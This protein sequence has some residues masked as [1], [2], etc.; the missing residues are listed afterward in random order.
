MADFQHGWLYVASG[1]FLPPTQ[2][3]QHN[4]FNLSNPANPLAVGTAPSIGNKPHSIGL[5]DHYIVHGGQTPSLYLYDFLTGA[6]VRTAVTGVNPVDMGAQP[7]FE[8]RATNGYISDP[9]Q[10][11][12]TRFD[13]DDP[14]AGSVTTVLAGL[15]AIGFKIGS[16]HPLGNLLV[17]S[18]SQA[19]G[20]ATF[21]IGDPLQPV[22]LDTLVT[23]NDVYTSMAYGS[24]LYACEAGQGI[25]VYDF[26][27]PRNVVETG[28]LPLPSSLEYNPRYVTI[29][30]GKGYVASGFV[31]GA[32]QGTLVE[33]DALA[34]SP[35]ITRTF[36]LGST[37]DWKYSDFA[38]PIGNMAFL[39]GSG[40]ATYSALIS[41]ESTADTLGPRV[42]HAN[43]PDFAVGVPTTARIGFSMSE[44]IDV[45]SL[46]A[47][48]FRL[49]PV[50]PPNSPA[51]TG[52]Y[53]VKHYGIINFAPDEPLLSNTTYE[54]D[55][56]FGGIRDLVGNGLRQAYHA[57]FTTGVGD[58][59]AS[60]RTHHWR[61]DGNELD[62]VGSNHGTPSATL[63]Y[64]PGQIG[65]AAYFDGAASIA[66]GT[67]SLPAS[68]S[69]SAWVWV[70]PTAT[71]SQTIIANSASG[72]SSPGYK[73]FVNSPGTTDGTVHL[74]TTT[75]LISADAVT[76]A[77]VLPAGSWHWVAVRR[78]GSTARIYVDGCDRTASSIVASGFTTSAVA[79]LG[80]TT[81]GVS[82][83]KGRLDDVQTYGTALSLEE[84][85]WL[86]G[87]R[88]APLI[89]GL[90]TN[91]N[92]VPT[93]TSVT[94]TATASDPNLDPLQYT[95]D[96][97]D[98]TSAG[99]SASNAATHSFT[100]AGRHTVTV[101][102]SDG[103]YVVSK[104]LIQVVHAPLT[105]S[106]PTHSSTI[107]Y[108]STRARIW[109][110][111]PD[112]HSVTCLEANSLVKL[113]EIE[114]AA[115][116]RFLAL[117]PGNA[118]LWVSSAR[119]PKVTVIDAASFAVLATIA[120]PQGSRPAGLAFAPNGTAAFLV[121]E[122]HGGIV[123]YDPVTRT[124][125]ATTPATPSAIR[126][127]AVAVSWDS[128][129]VYVPRFITGYINGR[130]DF[131]EVYTF[132][133]A[134]L[135]LL[136]GFALAADLSPDT[137]GSGGG[138]LNYLADLTLS[139]AGT[140]AWVVAKKDNTRRG[141]GSTG[142][143]AVNLPLTF[144]NTVRT[145]LTQLD[146]ATNQEVSSARIDVNDH[147]F[148][149][150][151]A[152]SQVGDL[153]FAA[154]PLN[155]DVLAFDA[156]TRNSLAGVTVGLAP[157]GLALSPD[158]LTLFVN[159][160]NQRRVSKLDVSGLVNG[161]SS[162]IPPPV[163]STAVT[164]EALPANVA[165]GK[166]VFFNAADP[167]MSRDGYLSCASCHLDGDGDGRV[168]DFTDRGQ[169]FRNT[170]DLRGHG[171]TAHGRVHWTANF[172]EIQDFEHDVRGSVLVINGQSFQNG[173][174]GTG[175]I[176]D[177][178]NGGQ[179]WP[180]LGASNQG[181]SA[182]LDDLAAYVSFLDGTSPSPFRAAD[183]N[184]TSTGALGK[185]HFESG[186][187]NC[188]ACHPRILF[189]DS[190]AGVVHDIGTGGSF[191]TPSLKGI[192]GTPPFL[193]DGRASSIEAVF[194]TLNA[195][196]GTAHAAV[197]TL[198]TQAQSELIAYLRELDDRETD[199]THLWM[200]NGNAN[201]SVGANHGTITGVA[202]G[203]GRFDQAGHFDGL[204]DHIALGT[205]NL[206]SVFTVTA[207][208]WVN[209]GT[210]GPQ[211]LIANGTSNTNV[212]SFRLQVNTLATGDGK[213]HFHTVNAS[214]TNSASTDAGA[215]TPGA[216][217]F[218][219]IT[220]SAG[221]GRIYVGGVD[222]TV[223]ASVHTSF[224]VNQA[225]RLGSTTNG[226]QRLSG[227]LDQVRVFARV[228]STHEIEML[229]SE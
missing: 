174:G 164:S 102:V 95:F 219:A 190:P 192:W 87:E 4:W 88:F 22:L 27:D 94:F 141:L 84:V 172:D 114:V 202:F 167:R 213:V 119:D 105:A 169:G 18:A 66:L 25:R 165:R 103:V 36:G 86:Y 126:A 180:P 8:Y 140:R 109:N 40:S 193:H 104:S 195:P 91:D 107:V 158:G 77:G 106:Q 19:K 214:G 20:V 33:F 218:I 160:A 24:R 226:A 92:I 47:G 200:L 171:G 182:D 43:P 196:A 79:Y 65:Q 55:L 110:T 14:G 173:Q 142:P 188:S 162:T 127:R 9:S 31:T 111:N 129:R 42:E 90:A 45:T 163:A 204:D 178:V 121:L 146:P 187:Q 154:F 222:R 166:Q 112:S 21:D 58:L 208:V 69:I 3:S 206:G 6:L 67:L 70:D 227:R 89:S 134:T 201:D 221:V 224:G 149:L 179:P 97:G 64:G 216:W 41:L 100:A 217:H 39:G 184:L 210:T 185:T 46:N 57:T 159:E 118:E 168:W 1:G 32:A 128:T 170:I 93:G 124:A 153:V 181:R 228:L 23:G 85:A 74:K 12:I 13:P 60:G 53:S 49:R 155:N 54:V 123:R 161:T 34:A 76:G 5:W 30:D 7:P 198:T 52:T 144:E 50:C 113:A 143:L 133:A 220:R 151:A 56:A 10:M 135:A 147:G 177:S 116:P 139:P 72:S 176:G 205:L 132:D 61:L 194:D 17:C 150:A 29:K 35:T 203:A 148:A 138:I 223:D 120:A 44:H 207:W 122:N 209:S 156:V 81:N 125:T 175:L 183:G 229:A 51:V 189:T 197:R 115:E 68:F 62:A 117:R 191:D 80:Q 137:E 186:G 96:F 212:A 101:H 108:D 26:S 157:D 2:T 75:S 131:A 130:T 48:T 82:R 63:T 199:A 16:S 37:G 83:L 136:P 28:F 215:V 15:G 98:G 11:A 71:G 99:P 78:S 38:M 152:F 211:T 73:L 145:V 59:V 225:T